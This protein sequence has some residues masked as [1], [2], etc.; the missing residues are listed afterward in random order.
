MNKNEY[1]DSNSRSTW[2]RSSVILGSSVASLFAL[3]QSANAQV[4]QT[5]GDAYGTSSL[6]SGT[7]WSDGQ[8]PSAGKTYTTDVLL[9]TPD[10]ADSFTFEGDSLTLDS[11]GILS[12][13]GSTYANP[14]ITV[15]LIMNGGYITSNGLAF[16]LDGTIDLQV[17]GDTNIYGYDG[18]LTIDSLITGGDSSRLV[19]GG[20]GLSPDPDLTGGVVFANGDNSFEGGIYISNYASVYVTA[21]GALGS[22]DIRMVDNSSLTLTGGTTN[23]YIDDGA[24]IIANSGIY[25]I[26]LD[27][28]GTDNIAAITLDA[29]V[30]YG[31]AGTYGAIGS[32]ADFEYAVFTGTGFLRVIPEPATS[33]LLIGA[34]VLCGV[35]RR[36]VQR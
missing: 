32:G 15:S 30:T 31:E 17:V 22:G 20:V 26:N 29:G 12:Y 3:A 4:T 28:I 27:F 23:D 9:R 18:L 6:N 11:G 13:K 5:T 35:M 34:L 33:S 24:T 2:L 21:D 14:T 8:A 7:N 1:K 10:S 19:I 36:R 25:T 16:T